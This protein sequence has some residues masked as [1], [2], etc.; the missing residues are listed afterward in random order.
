MAKKKDTELESS[1]TMTEEAPKSKDEV[2]ITHPDE[3][4]KLQDDRK[5]AG[6]SGWFFDG[7]DADGQPTRLPSKNEQ[8]SFVFV[9]GAKGICKVVP[10]MLLVLMVAIGS[11]FAAVASTDEA[12]HG[13]DRWSVQ[14]DGD[15]VPG[16]DSVYDIGASGN[17]VSNLY[18]D[19]VT[20]TGNLAFQSTL[21]AEGR[22]GAS[23]QVASSSTNLAPVNLP[24][25]VLLKNIG[26][27]PGPDGTG[28]GSELHD[29][30]AGQTLSIIITSGNGGGT[31]VL[32][33]DT[34]TG[35]TKLTFALKGQIA[36][37]VYVDDSIG[38]VIDSVGSSAA[39]DLPTITTEVFNGN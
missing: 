17:E 14:N 35:W 11:A 23:T 33:P 37:L 21:V 4:K 1:E 32:T 20:M 7:K 15:L 19:D 36:T 34:S 39:L 30:V 26:F 5:L 3:L 22:P 25:G 12:V 31:W 8:G 24:F 18:V 2:V 13:N 10:V 16:A 9:K 29:G 28:V 27:A 38:W 6:F